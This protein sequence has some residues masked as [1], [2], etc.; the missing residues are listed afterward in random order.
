MRHFILPGYRPRL[1][2]LGWRRNRP[3][4]LCEGFIVYGLDDYRLTMDPVRHSGQWR[5]SFHDG[6]DRVEDPRLFDDQFACADAALAHREER[7]AA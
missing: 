7:E 2:D 5:F 4:P 6:A 1:I 3:G